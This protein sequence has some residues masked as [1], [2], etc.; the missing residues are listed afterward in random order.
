MSGVQGETVTG[1]ETVA[2][3]VSNADTGN[4]MRVT[5]GFYIYNFTTK[6]LTQNQDYTLIVRL[7]TATGPIIQRA[8][9]RAGK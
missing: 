5:D 7:D 6:P 4:Q 8:V 9:L 3:S 2:T 1:T